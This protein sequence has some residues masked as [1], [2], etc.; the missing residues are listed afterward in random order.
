[1]YSNTILVAC[2]NKWAVL[3]TIKTK[4]KNKDDWMVCLGRTLSHLNTSTSLIIL[5]ILVV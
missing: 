3:Y 2:K 1:M 4:D 5:S